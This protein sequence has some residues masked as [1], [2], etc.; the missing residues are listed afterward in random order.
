MAH[1][2]VKIMLRSGNAIDACK[3]AAKFGSGGAQNG[4][5]RLSARTA[6]KCKKPY[7]QRCSGT[8]QL[9]HLS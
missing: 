8:F 3:I 9:I 1:R 2:Q 7:F 5:W 6:Q 4:R